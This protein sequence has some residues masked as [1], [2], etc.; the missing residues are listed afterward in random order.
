MP[1]TR[2]V[3]AKS[4]TTCET[5]RRRKRQPS[6]LRRPRAPPP[7][8]RLSRSAAVSAPWLARS[9][10]FHSIWASAASRSSHRRPQYRVPMSVPSTRR[11]APRSCS[12]IPNSR[13]D[14]LALAQTRLALGGRRRRRR[15]RLRGA[16][17]YARGAG[18]RDGTS[19]SVP[20]ESSPGADSHRCTS[21]RLHEPL[22]SVWARCARC[23]TRSSSRSKTATQSTLQCSRSTPTSAPLNVRR[24]DTAQ[25]RQITDQSLL[26]RK[27]NA[28]VYGL[29]DN[30][31]FEP[32]I[33]DVPAVVSS[34][35]L[36]PSHPS[37]ASR[38]SH[39]VI[40]VSG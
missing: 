32:C 4:C 12:L 14:E 1:Q 2:T 19:N 21:T 31:T 35:S 40:D 20:Q 26:R 34:L 5:P 13:N 33:I 16:G 9:R 8:A 24:A 18:R 25:D 39:P 15:R 23:R 37:H 28:K 22:R 29:P 27:V 6:S 38:P 30:H 3:S 17:G 11:A 10:A 36:H 7:V